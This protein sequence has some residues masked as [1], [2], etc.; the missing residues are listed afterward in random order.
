MP[1]SFVQIEQEK[2]KTIEWSVGLLFLLYFLAA[3]VIVFLVK[4]YLGGAWSHRYYYGLP[5][6]SWWSLFNW[7]T[8]GWT[9]LGAGLTGLAHWSYSTNALIDTTL[10]T[11][12]A[13]P[14]NPTVTSELTFKNVVSEA[15]VATGG[16]YQIEPWIIPTSAMNAFALQDFQGRSVIG[17]TEGLLLRLNREQLEAVIG[18]EA[19]HIASGDCLETTVTTVVFKVFDNVCDGA[20]NMLRFSGSG[21]S[22]RR[23]GGGQ[24]MLLILL[25]LVVAWVFK[26]IGTLGAMFVSRE[27]EYRAD[28]ISVRLTRNPKALAEALY[29]IDQRWKGSGIPGQSMDAIFILSPRKQAMED[30]ENFVADLFST[31]PPIQKRISIL[32]DMAHAP[33]GDLEIAARRSAEQVQVRAAE[34]PQ[35]ENKYQQWLA[36][37]DGKWVGPFTFGALQGFDWLRPDT[38]VKRLTEPATY[39]AG[40]VPGI[41][42]VF[43]SPLRGP[44]KDFCPRCNVKLTPCDYEGFPTLLCDRCNGRLVSEQDVLNI[45]GKREAQFEPRIQNMARLLREQA[46]PLKRG[47]LDKIY[48]EKSITCPSCLDAN[49]K[50][51]RRFVSPKYPVEIDKCPTC[52]RV[53]FDKDEMEV[54]QCLYEMEHP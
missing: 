44:V 26:L 21:R 13:R 17:I 25:V 1:Y 43:D 23:D 40:M 52:A 18:H 33:E 24:L 6:F 7:P 20:A 39:Q 16:K 51:R 11:M 30:N 49:N 22:S 41:K 47:P 46:Q 19:G 34:A 14:A 42:D 28:A 8:F 29:I 27:R 9:F 36:F 5:A 53:W 50:M 37:R 32:L 12:T 15:A 10:Q 48:N 45:V 4:A 38:M 3:L 31:H 35:P 2:S 54:L